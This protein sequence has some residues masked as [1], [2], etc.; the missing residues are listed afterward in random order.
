MSRA[1]SR[2]SVGNSTMTPS[3]APSRLSTATNTLPR[4]Q[5]R[6]SN[7]YSTLT[8][9]S[10][11]DDMKKKMRQESDVSMVTLLQPMESMYILNYR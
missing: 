9:F 1:T 2:M 3:R 5:S 7:A 11:D 10:V 8:V 6:Q 4:N